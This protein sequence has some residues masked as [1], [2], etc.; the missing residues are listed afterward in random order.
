MALMSEI[1]SKGLQRVAVLGL[2]A[3]L[4]VRCETSFELPELTL[5]PR[6][7]PFS[8]F[9]PSTTSTFI[10]FLPFLAPS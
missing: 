10:H 9:V 1:L 3:L 6:V 4:V 2:C 7:C 8:Y 5:S